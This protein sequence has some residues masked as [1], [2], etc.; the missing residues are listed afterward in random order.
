MTNRGQRFQPLSL[1]LNH[2][3]EKSPKV[4][5]SHCVT[6]QPKTNSSMTNG[7]SDCMPRSFNQH[8]RKLQISKLLLIPGTKAHPSLAQ[9]GNFRYRNLANIRIIRVLFEPERP[10]TRK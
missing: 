10:E 9:P 7:I 8:L 3:P 6:S 1:N 2:E 5:R 4:K